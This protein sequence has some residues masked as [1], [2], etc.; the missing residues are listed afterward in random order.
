VPALRVEH[1]GCH[2]AAHCPATPPDPCGGHET[3]KGPHLRPIKSLSPSEQQQIA[4]VWHAALQPANGGESLVSEAALLQ[5]LAGDLQAGHLAVVRQDDDIV[6][7]VICDLQQR[8]LRQL[9]VL[10]SCQGRGHGTRLLATAMQAM[11]GGWLRTDADNLRAQAFYD[12]RGL[13]VRRRGPHP[14]S[15][16]ATVEYGW[17]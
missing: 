7:F 11:P 15:Q 12:G 17:P 3:P 16:A 10:P 2:V 1:R 6:A 13:T 5:R 9:F 8:W 14:V 4:R